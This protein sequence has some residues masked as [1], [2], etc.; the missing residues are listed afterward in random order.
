M[1]NQTVIDCRPILGYQSGEKIIEYLKALGWV[2]LRG[3]V[4]DGNLQNMIEGIANSGKWKTVSTEGNREMKYDINSPIPKSWNHLILVK[5]KSEYFN[6]LI[7]KKTLGEDG[8]SISRF[9]IL[10]NAGIIPEDQNP[11]YYYPPCQVV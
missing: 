5:F 4:F 10:R 11:H 1:R 3:V 8:Y 7:S 9:N 6:K 2:D